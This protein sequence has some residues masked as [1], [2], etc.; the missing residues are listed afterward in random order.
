MGGSHLPQLRRFKAGTQRTR[1]L[2][3]I[4]NTGKIS[5]KEGCADGNQAGIVLSKFSRILLRDE[6]SKSVRRALINILGS[7]FTAGTSR[8]NNKL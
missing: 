5:R 6:F 7:T 2:G 1:N 3:Y 4:I 8:R